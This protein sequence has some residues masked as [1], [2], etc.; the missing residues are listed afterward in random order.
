[1]KIGIDV[2]FLTDEYIGIGRYSHCLLNEIASIDRENEYVIFKSPRHRGRV[3]DQANFREVVIRYAPISPSTLLTFGRAL[4]GEKLDVFHSHFYITPLVKPCK[5]VVTVHDITGLLFPRYY[6]ARPFILEKLV[7]YFH[8]LLIPYAIRQ[9][10]R[11]I[12]VSEF[13]KKCILR[14]VPGKPEDRIDVIYE[15][16][17]HNFKQQAEE[18]IAK[19]RKA[20]GLPERYFLYVG[21]TKPHKNLAGLTTAF[22][23]F[24]ESSSGH[25]DIRLIIAGKQDRFFPELKK[26]ISS[27]K[28]GDKVI[29][30]GY[31][32]EGDLPAFYAGALAFVFPGFLEGFG[33]PVLE[34]MACGTPTIT[35]N[36]SSIPEV[37]GDAGLLFDPE[38]TRGLADAM[39]RVADDEGFR[40]DLASKAVARAA[41]FSWRKAALETIATY[42]KLM[43]MKQ[44][45]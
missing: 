27:L 17:E 9:S 7:L 33:L 23:I 37:V 39:K 31:I 43:N 16:T 11:V 10:D 21:N 15:G 8:K 3:I 34:A 2:R 45:G 18:E 29:C 30:C 38:D 6:S 12:A 22:S 14:I 19:V 4:K 41:S 32:P 28:H 36:A 1:M 13:T 40:N 42:E 44:P 20:H 26:H 24:L 35:S 5:Q 25:H